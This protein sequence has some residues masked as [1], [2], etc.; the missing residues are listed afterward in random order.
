M[1]KK[2][3]TLAPGSGAGT[4]KASGKGTNTKNKA[5]SSTAHGTGTGIGAD[6]V[7]EWGKKNYAV[8]KRMVNKVIRYLKHRAMIDGTNEFAT[9]SHYDWWKFKHFIA[10]CMG[11]NVNN[12]FG[13]VF[14]QDDLRGD[15]YFP[16]FFTA[17]TA[18][19]HEYWMQN[20]RELLNLLL[21]FA[22]CYRV[23]HGQHDARKKLEIFYSNLMGHHIAATNEKLQEQLEAKKAGEKYGFFEDIRD[24]IFCEREKTIK[25]IF[26]WEKRSRADYKRERKRERKRKRKHLN[27]DRKTTHAL[28][29]YLKQPIIGDRFQLGFN[30]CSE[31]DNERFNKPYIMVWD[32][33]LRVEQT[34]LKVHS[35]D[36][37][38]KFS[39]YSGAKALDEDI[40]D[41]TDN[42]L[43]LPPAQ[44]AP[45]IHNITGNYEEPQDDYEL[46]MY[47]GGY[48]DFGEY[49]DDY[50]AARI[51]FGEYVLTRRCVFSIGKGN[52]AR[53]AKILTQLMRQ[54]E[55]EAL[56]Y[57]KHQ[58]GKEV[59]DE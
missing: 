3:K 25:E 43:N 1:S 9:K 18:Q 17:Y 42:K 34:Y 16:D 37:D 40:Q 14:D 13:V 19:T 8:H 51:Q 11:N 21:D 58:P 35:H 10:A 15:T 28:R 26:T 39:L 38:H 7:N 56:L 50:V 47:G 48:V 45:I 5:E 30:G 33:K 31:T 41:I 12:Y 24:E 52:I 23:P 44:V 57:E 22:K 59:D 4:A 46:D 53:G 2:E 55:M 54:K 36:M 32:H 27:K 29:Q 20:Y 6:S 49:H